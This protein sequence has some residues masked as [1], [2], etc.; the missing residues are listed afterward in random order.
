MSLWK[1]IKI[2]FCCWS[3]CSFS[4][5]EEKEEIE[6]PPKYLETEI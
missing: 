1:K 5:N 4:L 3:K 6:I 2:K